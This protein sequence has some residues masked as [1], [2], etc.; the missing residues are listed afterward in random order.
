M[1]RALAPLLYADEELAE[2]RRTRDPVLPAEASESAKL[3]KSEHRTKEGLLVQKWS[4]LIQS[5]G[6]LCRNTCRMK[7]DP[8]SPS[9]VRETDPDALQQRVFELL[10]CTQYHEGPL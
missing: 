8:D 5:L 4:S 10:E 3:K 9:F 2:L 7:D 6:T 1:R